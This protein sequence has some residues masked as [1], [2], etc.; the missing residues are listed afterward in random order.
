MLVRLCAITLVLLTACNADDDPAGVPA[1][2]TATAGETV[3]PEPSTTTTTEPCDPGGRPKRVEGV[4]VRRFC[5]PARARIA[6]GEDTFRFSGGACVRT[7]E[8]FELNL[9]LAV[10]EPDKPSEAAREAV[11]P[12][13]RSVSILL[14]RHEAA[15]EDAPPVS[16]DGTYHEGVITLTVPG[17]AYL[18]DDK[19]VTLIGTR[20]AGRFG[21]R[22]LSGEDRKQRGPSDPTG[23]PEELPGVEVS[24]LFTCDRSSISLNEVAA[25]LETD[26]QGRIKRDVDA[27]SGEDAL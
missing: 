16:E 2:T 3:A 18:V 15:S 11:A 14:G 27:E 5:G 19:T 6:L 22:A 23:E 1:S 12:R 24:G 8:A 13:F 25:R 20:T 10:V 7:A 9:G 17:T 26:P 4:R 21:G